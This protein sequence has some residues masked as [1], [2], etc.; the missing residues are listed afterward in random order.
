MCFVICGVVLLVMNNFV[1]LCFGGKVLVIVWL[2][3]RIDAFVIIL[4]ML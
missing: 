2:A 3:F 1:I 4:V